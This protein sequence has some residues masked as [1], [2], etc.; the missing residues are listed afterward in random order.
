M[1]V[2]RRFRGTVAV[3]LFILSMASTGTAKY[4]GGTGEPND[5]Y[6]IATAAD[7]IALGSE[8]DDYSKH[9]ILTTDIDLDPNLPGGRAFDKAVIAADTDDQQSGFQG[10]AFSG[11]FD[12][13]GHVAR[14]VHVNAPGGDSVGLFGRVDRDARIQNLGM[15]DANI[16]GV[17]HVGALA[18][19]NFGLLSHCWSTGTVIGTGACIGGLVGTSGLTGVKTDVEVRNCQST[20]TVRGTGLCI[21]GLVG[22]NSYGLVAGCRGAGSVTG[23][24][25]GGIPTHVGGLVGYNNRGA[26]RDSYSTGSVNAIDEEVRSST[27]AGGLVGYDEEGAVSRSYSAGLV[28]EPGSYVGGLIGTNSSGSAVAMS[29]WDTQISGQTMSAGGTGLKTIEMQTAKTFLDAGWDFAGEADNGTEDIWW[30]FEGKDYPRLRWERVLGDDFGDGKA[31]PLWFAYEPEPDVVRLREVNGRLEVE[32]VAQEEDVD[33]IYAA[34]GWR[35]DVAKGFAL[36]VDF[37]FSKSG[38]GD[39]RVTLGVVPSLDPSGMRWAELEAGCFDTDPFYLYEVRDKGWV[40]ERVKDRSS[41]DGTVYM[42]Y[43]SETDELYFSYSGY[44]KANAWQTMPGLLKGRWASETVYVIL[45]GGSQ[46]MALEP[47]DAWL[48]DLIIN[49]G[50][51]LPPDPTDDSDPGD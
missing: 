32:A 41:N 9:F 24:A 31:E 42:S 18:G 47:G 8:P 48:D 3:S 6:Q 21:G 2:A 37:H 20:C 10:A 28:R 11:V 25:K 7:L 34:N 19:V 46:G 23:Q 40:Q 43:D 36:R 4:S 26:V 38:V 22:M 30:I 14:N 44:G 17:G 12:G 5:P 51:L 29:F 50:T 49:S 33:S 16:V 45:S 39:G 1:N 27:A 15:E 13:N 35:L